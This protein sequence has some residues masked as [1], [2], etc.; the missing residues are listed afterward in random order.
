MWVVLTLSKLKESAVSLTKRTFSYALS[1]RCYNLVA[2]SRFHN[3]VETLPRSMHEYLGA[4]LLCTFRQDVVGSS[5][6]WSHA[7][8]NEKNKN[9]KNSKFEISPIFIELW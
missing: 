4:N 7:N 9:G 2:V 8:E 6:I 5:P 3:L 1:V